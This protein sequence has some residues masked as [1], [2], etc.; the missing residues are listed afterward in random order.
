MAYKNKGIK[1]M[2][3]MERDTT[4]AFIK[5]QF[6]TL[7][8]ATGK[9]KPVTANTEYILGIALESISAND[10]SKKTSIGFERL[11]PEEDEVAVDTATALTSAL[12]GQLASLDA[13]WTATTAIPV[14]LIVV[15]GTSKAQFRV[16]QVLG[17]NLAVVVPIGA[18]ENYPSQAVA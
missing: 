8:L 5:G 15:S 2:E 6:L 14:K 16:K 18:F 1:K 17:A 13:T 3:E 9:V 7:N 10:V 12:V 4:L 11:T